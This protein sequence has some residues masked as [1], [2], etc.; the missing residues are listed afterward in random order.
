MV[1]EG[2]REAMKPRWR[3]RV[4]FLIWMLGSVLLPTLPAGAQF[5]AV[6]FSSS[7]NPVGSGA[8]ALGMGGA[9]IG[10]A[11]DAT[12]ASW[13]PGGLIQLETPEISIVGA[14]N[15]RT[16][17]SRYRAFPEASG[18]QR[19]ETSEL[20][21]LSL[22]YP[23]T[24]GPRNMIVALNYQ[25]LYDFTKEV[26]YS[27]R[28]V[29][30]P[31]DIYNRLRF[32]QSGALRTITP[33]AAVQVTPA[34]SVGLA[35]NFWRDALQENGW[36]SKQYIDGEGR[37]GVNDVITHA[38]VLEENSF[39]GFNYTVG[40]LWRIG[41]VF[42]LGGVFK[43]PFEADLEYS[44]RFDY[45]ISFPAVPAANT[46]GTVLEPLE[47]RAL[48]MPLSYGMG[49]GIRI[50]DA[51]SLDFDVYRTAWS[52]YVLHKANGEKVSPI[53]GKPLA[54]SDVEDTTQLRMGGEYLFIGNR[55]VIPL[56]LG[57]FYDP[58]P[59]DGSPDDFYGVSVGGGVAFG[60]VIWDV[61]YQYRFGR[62]VNT[63][64][65]GEEDSVQDVDQH[66]IYMSLIYHF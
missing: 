21:Y 29:N 42:T 43:S 46:R 58:E 57:V 66:T 26:R 28:S 23:F 6:E 15:T 5:Q 35:F 30:G 65:V 14:F 22:A 44:S 11:D 48:D 25:Q 53:T 16:E 10:V 9:F 34:L 4:F 60:P 37:I 32:E 61:A 2:G 62:D 38:V 27:F 59:A 1:H 3:W 55:V 12:A 40:F 8:R 64:T 45:S 17:D 18:P 36:S 24:V 13:N 63:V 31:E 41:D 52:D 20:N 39:E 54:E 50:S 47:K 49:L 56:R 7:P 33:A 51:L 19:F